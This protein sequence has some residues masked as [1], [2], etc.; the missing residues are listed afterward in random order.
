[1]T[2]FISF[3]PLSLTVHQKRCDS[4]TLPTIERIRLFLVCA[5]MDGTIPLHH[6]LRMPASQRTP[7]HIRKKR[8]M[9]SDFTNKVT[10]IFHEKPIRFDGYS[11]RAFFLNPHVRGMEDGRQGMAGNGHASR[12]GKEMD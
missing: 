3:P 5:N 7:N 2:C 1:M 11:L 8:K 9:S 6:L 4:P 12:V 10:L